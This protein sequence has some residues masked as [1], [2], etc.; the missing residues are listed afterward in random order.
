MWYIL[1]P[2]PVIFFSLTWVRGG[3]A[4]NFGDKTTSSD[5]LRKYAPTKLG[6]VIN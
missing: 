4:Q 2:S 6:D 1:P 3:G 5:T